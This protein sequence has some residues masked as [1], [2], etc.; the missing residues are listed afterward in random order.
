MNNVI[1][2]NGEFDLEM[3]VDD[4]IFKAKQFGVARVYWLPEFV[5]DED[6]VVLLDILRDLSADGV[7]VDFVITDSSSNKTLTLPYMAY[8]EGLSN[9]LVLKTKEIQNVV[10]NNIFTNDFITPIK[11]GG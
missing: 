9:V 8:K 2:V 3:L 10:D 6:I 1:V 4:I 5:T 7:Y 11:I